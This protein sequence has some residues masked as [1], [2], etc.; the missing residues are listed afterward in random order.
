[1]TVLKAVLEQPKFNVFGKIQEHKDKILLLIVF[2]LIGY[3]AY[4]DYT[5]MKLSRELNWNSKL[6]ACMF[7]SVCREK[8][9]T[10]NLNMQKQEIGD[11]IWKYDV[12]QIITKHPDIWQK[13]DQ[14]RRAQILEKIGA[15]NTK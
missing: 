7:D 8:I 10:F 11:I 1:M 14:K 15:I 13:V 6:A 12:E 4:Q 2:S 3:G 5:I 9:D